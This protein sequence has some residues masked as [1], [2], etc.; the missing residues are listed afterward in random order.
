MLVT[1]MRSYVRTGLQDHKGSTCLQEKE[2]CERL[3]GYFDEDGYLN[4]QLSVTRAIGDWHMKKE[5][6]VIAEPDVRQM[7]L[8]DNDEFTGSKLCFH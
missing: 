1:L 2:R 8:T 6:L 7:V 3:G 4:G 5:K